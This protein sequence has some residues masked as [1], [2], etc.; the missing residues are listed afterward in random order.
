MHLKKMNTALNYCIKIMEKISELLHQKMTKYRKFYRQSPTKI[1]ETC[2]DS[3]KHQLFLLSTPNF[4]AEF[5][6]SFSLKHMN[7]TLII[8]RW[9]KLVSWFLWKIVWI[10]K[11]MNREGFK[12]IKRYLLHHIEK[13]SHTNN[14]LSQFITTSHSNIKRN[15]FLQRHIK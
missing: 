15:M 3:I 1:V 6:R 11:K 12:F 4:N 7:T 9:R 14:I 5:A 10:F 13:E 2:I 8:L